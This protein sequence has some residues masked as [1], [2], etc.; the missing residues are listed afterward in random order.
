MFGG[1]PAQDEPVGI[2]GSPH[3]LIALLHHKVLQFIAPLA[4]D[5]MTK[6]CQTRPLPMHGFGKG[7]LLVKMKV[8]IPKDLD[9]KQEKL[10]KELQD[11]LS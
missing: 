6:R 5:I 10:L 1:E 7:D 3:K 8:T 2:A 9:K 4:H 11:T